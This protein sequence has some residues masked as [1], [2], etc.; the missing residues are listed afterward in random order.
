M[1]LTMTG[2]GKAKRVWGYKN[3]VINEEFVKNP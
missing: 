1:R 3:A 2:C